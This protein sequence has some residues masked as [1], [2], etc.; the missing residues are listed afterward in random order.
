MIRARVLAV[1]S[2]LAV[3]TA[4]SARVRAFAAL[5]RSGPRRPHVSSRPG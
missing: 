1:A 2:F 4:T 3:T 5:R